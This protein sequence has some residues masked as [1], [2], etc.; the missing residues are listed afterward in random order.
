[1]IKSKIN[2]T[3]KK[4]YKTVNLFSP[5]ETQYK[6]SKSGNDYC[7]ILVKRSVFT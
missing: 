2:I 7:I 3:K 1:M 6:L 5:E 4:I